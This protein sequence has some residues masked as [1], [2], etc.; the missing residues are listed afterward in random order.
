MNGFNPFYNNNNFMP[1][2]I[3]NNMMMPGMNFGGNESWMSGYGPGINF[4]M[5]QMQVPI[6]PGSNKINIVFKTTANVRTN[7]VAEY[8]K[9]VSD[10]IL[11]YLKR[12]GREDLFK[13][14]S[15]ICFLNNAKKIDIYD[16][17][18]VEIYFKNTSS[19]LIIVND[20]QNLI[21]ARI[22]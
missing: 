4:N 7:V 10:I 12:V 3:N 1:M 20:V 17:T 8:G 2:F 14:D 21:G 16:K 9:T 5:G 13:K 6:A 22:I 18:K 11:L 19:P 15:G